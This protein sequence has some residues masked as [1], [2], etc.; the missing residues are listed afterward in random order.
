M[1]GLEHNGQRYLVLQAL[2]KARV[3]LPWLS[4]CVKHHC[5]SSE[6]SH[7]LGLCW[8]WIGQLTWQRGQPAKPSPEKIQLENIGFLSG[9][10]FICPLLEE[11]MAVC[12]Y[13]ITV[14][15]S[16]TI[17]HCRLILMTFLIFIIILAEPVSVWL[18]VQ[19][20]YIGL[21][22]QWPEQKHCNA[23]IQNVFG[24]QTGAVP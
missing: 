1:I 12:L 8:L 6:A 21:M 5:H 7:S 9:Q 24:T 4:L 2:S 10:Q 11:F 20:E 3:V 22:S 13:I 14:S 15:C 19:V 17:L 16:Q 23:Q 18:N